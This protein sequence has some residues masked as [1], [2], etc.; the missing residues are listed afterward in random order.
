MTPV[1][2]THLDVY[3]RQ[4]DSQMVTMSHVGKSTVT[5]QASS[6]ASN[7]ASLSSLQVSPG[8]LSPEFSAD[9]DAYSVNV[10]L[11]VSR[12]TISVTTADPNAS[13]AAVSYTHL[14]VYKRQFW[15]WQLFQL[16]HFTCHARNTLLKAL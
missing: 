15:Y 3:K 11:D 9:T 5:V 1:S 4:A 2:Y 12:L 6:S 10:G 8:T 7:N 14:D 13:Y 16:W